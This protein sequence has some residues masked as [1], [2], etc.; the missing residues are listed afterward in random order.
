MDDSP[1]SPILASSP[2]PVRDDDQRTA[3][4]RAIGRLRFKIRGLERDGERDDRVA[5]LRAELQA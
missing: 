5:P 2:S 3:L 1:V 4:Y